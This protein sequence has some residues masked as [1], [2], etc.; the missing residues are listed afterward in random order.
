[1]G[2]AQVFTFTKDLTREDWLEARRHGLG[3]SDIAAI[4]GISP[5]QSPMS[6]YM[7][8]I[9]EVPDR[10]ESEV[11][12]WGTRLEDIVA[13]EFTRRTGLK[14]MR[15]NA[16]LQHPQYHWMLANIDRRIVGQKSGLECKTTSA[17]GKEAWEDDKVPDMYQLQCQ[18]YMAVTG[19]ESWWIAV[20]I[21]G[22]TFRYTEIKRDEEIIQ[23]IT[24]IGQDFWELVE[25]KTPPEIDGTESSTEVLNV[26]YPPEKAT[27]DEIHIIGADSI[28]AD[29]LHAQQMEKDWKE[30]KDEAANRLKNLMKNCSIGYTGSHKLSWK[31]V[32][33]NRVDT[34]AL[35]KAGLYEQYSKQS[36]TRRFLVSEIK[37]AK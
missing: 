21:G 6:V 9:G 7:E 36:S 27:K 13:E 19:Y 3:G 15:Q 1:M 5:W 8:K 25:R 22:N 20:L 35:K 29:F 12:Y 11:M 26:L 32:T 18:W 28:L 31:P 23:Y 24:K 34:D 4:A 10:E 2:Q 17:Y 37:E 14:V 30:A 16:I 33:S